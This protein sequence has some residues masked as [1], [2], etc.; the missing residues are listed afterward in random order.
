MVNKSHETTLFMHKY[1]FKYFQ[2]SLYKKAS[3]AQETEQ[4]FKHGT[5]STSD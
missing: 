2:S 1:Q 3:K 5:M 4:V